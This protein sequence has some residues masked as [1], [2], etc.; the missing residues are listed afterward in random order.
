MLTLRKIKYGVWRAVEVPWPNPVI[1][2][3]GWRLNI[4]GTDNL[5]CFSEPALSH[6]FSIFLLRTCSLS[7]LCKTKIILTGV[8]QASHQSKKTV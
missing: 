2:L 1:I 7:K 6:Q 5:S 3:H 4:I 8:T